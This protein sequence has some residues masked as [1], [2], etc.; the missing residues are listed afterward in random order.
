MEAN[1]HQVPAIRPQDPPEVTTVKILPNPDEQAEL[2]IIRMFATVMDEAVTVPGTKL[3]FG[4]DAI[5]GLLPGIGD[6]GS[7]AI[8]AYLLRAASRLGVP[9]V[10]QL[11]MLLNIF[12]DT[13][14][15][16]VPIVGDYL[17]ILFKSNV[18]NA[19]LIL[20]AVENRKTAARSS[21][22]TLI[23][24]FTLF[25]LITVGGFVGTIFVVKWIWNALG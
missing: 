5:L 8:S 2:E 14:L 9:M 3:K 18:R 6:L 1:A 22:F 4:L 16:L 7:A 10:V 21:W 23:G 15:G 24:V 13:M 25:I 12:I 19:N 17:D 11:R 20:H